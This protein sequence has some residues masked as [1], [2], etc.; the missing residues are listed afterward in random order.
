MPLPLALTVVCAEEGGETI[1]YVFNCG[2]PH[3]CPRAIF[4]LLFLPRTM[5]KQNGKFMKLF[6]VKTVAAAAS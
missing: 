4:S 3:I 1:D 2:K 5:G 6:M